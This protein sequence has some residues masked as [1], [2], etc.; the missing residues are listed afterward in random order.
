VVT[1]QSDA[2]LQDAELQVV[3]QYLLRNDPAGVRIAKVLRPTYDLLL[4]GQH[5]G[6]YRWDQLYKT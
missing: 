6:R 1:V 5:T 3:A 4:D 2:E